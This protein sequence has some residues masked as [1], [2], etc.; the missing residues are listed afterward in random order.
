MTPL[1][2]AWRTTMR[3][4]VRAALAIAGVAVIGALL[5]DMLLLSNGLLASFSDLLRS[6]GFEIRV[7]AREG[8]VRVGIPGAV[9]TAA[10]IRAL[11][12][13]SDVALI[14]IEVGRAA[15]GD[16]HVSPLT[17]VGRTQS[18]PAPWRLLAGDN[19]PEHADAESCPVVIGRPL[20]TALDLRPG[21]PVQITAAPPGAATAYP[22]IACRVSGIADFGFAAANEFTAATPMPAF[23]RIIGERV[24]GDAELVLVAVRSGGDAAAVARTIAQLRPDLRVYSNDDVVAQ[25]NRNGFAYFRQIST[26]LSALTTSFAFLLIATL[27]TVSINQRLG[28]IAA[29]RALGIRRRRISAMLLWE[30]ALLVGAGALLALP[31]GAVIAVG[32][33]HILRQMPGLPERLHFFVFEPRALVIHVMV[34]LITATAAAVYPIWLAATLPI[35]ATLRREVI[36]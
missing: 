31:L 27:L 3:Y 20:S 7:V 12:D 35:A 22:P 24:P 21:S 1:Q 29:L 18:Q 8:F 5:F 23:E 11:P 2:L 19:L 33:D 25:F 32:L 15:A 30:S 10:T 26:V 16:K 17:I 4:R 36:G 28:E 34:F 9:Q 13:V 6:E 14:R